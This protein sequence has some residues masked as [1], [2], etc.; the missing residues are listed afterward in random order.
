MKTQILANEKKEVW[1]G[2]CIGFTCDSLSKLSAV[3]NYQQHAWAPRLACKLTEAEAHHQ[4]WFV[5]EQRTGWLQGS[6]HSSGFRLHMVR[7]AHGST[8][9]SQP[10]HF[11]DISMFFSWE[12]ERESTNLHACLQTFHSVITTPH[13]EVF[14]TCTHSIPTSRNRSRRNSQPHSLNL[15]TSQVMAAKWIICKTHIISSPFP[16]WVTLDKLLTLSVLYFLLEYWGHKDQ[17]S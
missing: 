14:I 16:S 7:S 1:M 6:R 12:L 11:Q 2:T 15:I 13:V 3:W 17:M 8:D 9:T 4:L 5:Q 10:W